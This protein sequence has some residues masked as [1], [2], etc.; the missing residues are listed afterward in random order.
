MKNILIAKIVSSNCNKTI[1]KVSPIISGLSHV[2]LIEI[3]T[4][5]VRAI[6][7]FN[8]RDAR[9]GYKVF[10]SIES[11]EKAIASS[12]EQLKE[13]SLNRIRGT[14][15]ANENNIDLGFDV[16]DASIFEVEIFQYSKKGNK[17]GYLP[18]SVFSFNEYLDKKE[19]KVLYLEIE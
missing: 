2:N 12:N 17:K 8:H 11:I 9:I 1:I 4:T 3:E 15:K 18:E 5:L 19:G 13:L 7:H 10:N 16:Y 6:S 14:I